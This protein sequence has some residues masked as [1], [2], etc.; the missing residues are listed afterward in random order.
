M[1]KTRNIF[2]EL[3]NATSVGGVDTSMQSPDID[4]DV[5]GRALV[6]QAAPE[7]VLL[8]L[9]ETADEAQLYTVGVLQAATTEDENS[10]WT[11]PSGKPLWI[12]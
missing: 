1:E 10:C 4:A 11:L 7:E 12:D 2:E 3:K 6:G 8:W 9:Y 5:L